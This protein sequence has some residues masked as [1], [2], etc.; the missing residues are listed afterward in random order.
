MYYNCITKLNL[1]P[2]AMR[3]VLSISL[4][5]KVKKEIEKRAQKAKKTVSGYIVYAL[6]LEK[7]LISEDE[8]FKAAKKAEKDY[9]AGRTKE[10]KSLADLIKK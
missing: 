1:N 4:P 10:L 5:E 8:L 6:E 7:S 9:K 2:S 3:S